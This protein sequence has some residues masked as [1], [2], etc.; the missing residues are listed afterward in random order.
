MARGFSVSPPHP[1]AHIP[2]YCPHPLTRHVVL[3]PGP[4][5]GLALGWVTLASWWTVKLGL[6]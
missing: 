4:L 3:S 6:M 2:G 1:G 5:G